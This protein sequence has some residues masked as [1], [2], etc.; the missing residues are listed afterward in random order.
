MADYIPV[1]QLPSAR[2][3]RGV[4][5][6][7]T[8]TPCH[9][10]DT[11]HL[12][13]NAFPRIALVGCGRWGRNILRD[14]LSLGCTVH[15]S[16]PAEKARAEASLRGAA[17]TCSGTDGLPE[18]DG[19]IIATPTSTHGKLAHE[20]LSQGVP[21]YVEKPLADDPLAAARLV[22][23]G[24]GR[25]F[26]MH[27]WRYHP[28][29][30]AVAHI[31]AEGSLGRVAGLRTA[32]MQCGYDHVDVDPIW[33]LAPHD[34]SIAVAVLGHIPPLR[35][36]RAHFV[37]HRVCGATVLF[38]DDP[39]LSC[40]ISVCSHERRREVT[41][42]C[43]YG[44]AVLPGP[45]SEHIEVIRFECS[46]RR[47]VPEASRLPISDELPLLR[48]LRAF[49]DHLRGGPPPLASAEEGAAVV[50][51]IAALLEHCGAEELQ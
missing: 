41:L 51:A 19:V 36:A 45:E 15:V 14:L 2:L 5:D 3:I 31:A 20:F 23:E 22:R 39:W 49:C 32:R 29:V 21:V 50:A 8:P 48:E 7:R 38:G 12:T 25:L 1:V 34:L 33:T 37:D 18:V 44:M 30:E 4:C 27:K 42:L 28:G 10:G 11:S 40:D 13:M 17:S 9:S 16:D 35:S 46:G 26:V 24:A 43:Q 6:N 47:L